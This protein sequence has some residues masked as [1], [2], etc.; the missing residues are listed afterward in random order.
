MLRS[1]IV[2]LKKIYKFGL[3]RFFDKM[4]GF[5]SNREKCY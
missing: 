4:H 2:H 1:K 5:S 3:D